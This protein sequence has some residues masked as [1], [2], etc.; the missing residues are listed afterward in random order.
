MRAQ[1][2]PPPLPAAATYPAATLYRSISAYQT[3]SL[4]FTHVYTTS[5]GSRHSRSP[6]PR[7]PML[8]SLVHVRAGPSRA[9]CKSRT[10]PATLNRT[11]S[12]RHRSLTWQRNI[13]A[14]NG[15]TRHAA[16]PQTSML[17]PRKRK[18]HAGIR[19]ATIMHHAPLA[20]SANGPRTK[21]VRTR[22]EMKCSPAY[23]AG[24]TLAQQP[25]SRAID[26]PP[27]PKTQL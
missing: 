27:L 22:G 9:R 23:A 24:M 21:A 6:K 18:L 7:R 5:I 8:S 10:H 26:T 19:K 11:S 17:L 16:V 12:L 2:A 20:R 1:T 25:T 15:T 13:T 4:P 3:G 14:R